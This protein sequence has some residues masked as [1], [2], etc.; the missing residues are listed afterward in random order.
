MAENVPRGTLALLD[1]G[2]AHS[3]A[4]PSKCIHEGEDVQTWLTTYAYTHIMTFLL[5]L[6][7]S[8]FPSR[9]PHSPNVQSWHLDSQNAATS[10]AIR[11]LGEML[12]K[13]EAIV[14]QA[15]PD[16]GPRR[17]GNRSFRKWHQIVGETVDE[18]LE[19]HLPEQVL[20]FGEA[21]RRAREDAIRPVDEL[22]EYL[23]GSF[24]SAQRLDYGTGHELSFL[25]FL[26]GVWK[27]G[28]FDANSDPW[29]TEERGIVLEVI[30]PYLRLIRK[31]ILTYTLEPAGSHGV[32]GLDDHSFLPYIFGSAQLSPAITTPAEIPSEGSAPDAPKSG[33]VVK[34]MTVDRER[35]KNMYFSAVGFIY[36]VKRGP[37]W[38]HSPILFDISG[39]TAGWAKI[40]KGMIK[41]YNAEVLAKFPVVQHFPFGSL[42]PWTHD[43]DAPVPITTTHT[44]AQPSSQPSLHGARETSA[45]KPP[46]SVPTSTKRPPQMVGDIAGTK[47]PWLTG[48]THRTPA[49]P[50]ASL[51]G[52]TTSWT[53]QSGASGLPATK[54]PW[55]NARQGGTGSPI[56]F[57]ASNAAP[58]RGS[59]HSRT[60]LPAPS[61]GLSTAA[62]WTQTTI[63]TRKQPE[64]RE[65]D[66]AETPPAVGTR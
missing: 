13:L 16:P 12:T 25:A 35:K 9:L 62:S 49:M 31:L 61:P 17:F 36:D 7:A 32:W 4:I 1:P 24:G 27:L 45:P 63:S 65:E 20:R 41:M 37:F 55:A 52:P 8:M 33:D 11:S 56:R 50:G 34:S 46:S 54:A 48:T 22:K 28:G 53:G 15:P 57:P 2:E 10:P 23:L 21:G 44:N 42:F 40:N 19:L 29:G 47:A 60:H 18:L 6:N 59:Q 38:E 43:P 39:V 30:E 58:A 5:Q 51:P 3:F 64:L 66:E 26:A 14:D